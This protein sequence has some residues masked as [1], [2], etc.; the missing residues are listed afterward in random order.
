[1]GLVRPKG[2]DVDVVHGGESWTGDGSDEGD[3]LCGKERTTMQL[4]MN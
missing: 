4:K 1:M 3:G 2:V